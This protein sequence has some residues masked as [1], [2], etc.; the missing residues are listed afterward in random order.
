MNSILKGLKVTPANM[1][2]IVERLKTYFET[3]IGSE[4]TLIY[5]I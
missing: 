1:P 4:D 2:K 3:Y 5:N